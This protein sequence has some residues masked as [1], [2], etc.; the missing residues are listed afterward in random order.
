M[1]APPA[2]DCVVE[3]VFAYKGFADDV[4]VRQGAC[5]VL[6]DMGEVYGF[7]R[8][9]LQKAVTVVPKLGG[10]G[11]VFVGLLGEVLRECGVDQ[12]EDVRVC[13]D[14]GVKAWTGSLRSQVRSV[15]IDD[16]RP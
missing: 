4:A 5:G 12:W 13:V 3:V 1:L 11:D 16:Q 15:Y 9:D 6:E 10:R 2:C 7:V 14:D 8:R